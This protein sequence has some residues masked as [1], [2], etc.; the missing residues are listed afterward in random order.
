MDELPRFERHLRCE[1]AP[2]T[3]QTYL[4]SAE[5]LIEF[6]SSRGMPTSLQGISSEHRKEFMAGLLERWKP[7]TGRNRYLVS[8]SF[9]DGLLTRTN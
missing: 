1:K 6:L 3:I 5:R 4:E 7:A 2:R 8:S 9:S